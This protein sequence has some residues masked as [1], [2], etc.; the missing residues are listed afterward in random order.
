[1][2]IWQS[3][4][5][6]YL[7]A[8]GIHE[9]LNARW[10]FGN[11]LWLNWNNRVSSFYWTKGSKLCFLP[12]FSY[13]SC[14]FLILVFSWNCYLLISLRLSQLHGNPISCPVFLYL[15]H[16]KVVCPMCAPIFLAQNAWDFSKQDARGNLVVW[17]FPFPPFAEAFWC[18]HPLD[19][20]KSYLFYSQK[21][22]SST[23]LCDISPAKLSSTARVRN[24][25]GISNSWIRLIVA[26][27]MTA[28]GRFPSAICTWSHPSGFLALC[29]K[30]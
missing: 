27:P 16:F 20:C 3:L 21:S 14:Y 18:K 13:F 26:C 4:I 7:L 9:L 5:A 6:K 30:Q 23:F 8:I 1:M 12:R 22:S 29:S 25:Q 15:W 28:S 17:S 24:L 11:I 2:V 10:Q 19:E